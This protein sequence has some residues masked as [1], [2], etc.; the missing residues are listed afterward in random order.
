MRSPFGSSRR[1]VRRGVAAV[2]VG[3]AAAVVSLVFAPPVLADPSIPHGNFSVTYSKSWTYKF[4]AIGTCLLI[5]EA[6]RFSYTI[7]PHVGNHGGYYAWA[8]QKLNSPKL[9]AVTVAMGAKSTC[10]STRKAVSALDI[11]QHW[12]GYSCNFNPSISVGLPLALTFGFWPSCA[13]REQA[14]WSSNYGSGSK[15]YQNN[16]GSPASFG[17]YDA[18]SPLSASP[19]P[20]YGAFPSG[21]IKVPGYTGTFNVGNLNNSVKICLNKT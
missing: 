20:C 19:G 3:L 18:A 10:T 16:T 12:S 1:P 11:S 13:N 5:S 7:E 6:G 2:A 21:D 9:T 4:P 15:F 14:S 8:S 17:E